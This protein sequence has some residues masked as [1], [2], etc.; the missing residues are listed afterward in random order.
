MKSRPSF[1]SRIL[2]RN[3][4][5]QTRG[6]ITGLQL[7]GKAEVLRDRWGIPHIYAESM[8]DLLAAQGFVHAQDRLWQMESMRRLSEGR[9][10]EVAGDGTLF[11]DCFSRL[12]D[13]SFMKRQM[14]QAAT[15]G[16]RGLLQAYADGVNAYLAMRGKDLPLEFKSM[17]FVPEKWSAIDGLSTVPFLTWFL[18]GA[19]YSERL[20]ALARGCSLTS[21]D[22]NDMFPCYPGAVLPDDPYF[23]TLAHL[24]IGALHPAATAFHTGLSGK[25]SASSLRE[26]LLAG[27][28]VAAGS[29]MEIGAGPGGGSNNWTVAKGKDGLPLLANDP[30]LG[31]ALPAVWYF[32]H[33]CVPGE[34][35][36]AGTSLAGVPGIVIGRNEHVAWSMTNAMLD[37]VDVLMLRVDPKN[38]TRYMRGGSEREMRREDV[39]IGLPKGKSV[40]LPLYRTELGPAITAVTEGVEAVAALRW[41][42]TLPEGKIKDRSFGGIFSLLRARSAAEALEAARTM[43]YVSQNLVVADDKGHIAWHATGA[44][45]VRSG[46]SGRLPADG[47][48][49]ADWIGFVPYDSLPSLMDPPEGWIATAN[50]RPPGPEKGTPLSYTWCSPYRYQHIVHELSAMRS[51]RVRRL[52]RA[53]DECPF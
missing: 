10:S 4:W 36:V 46:Y 30:H 37:P 24:K 52:P 15:E 19:A 7:S 20:L 53:S 43:Y 25:Y 49:D 12:I 31:V 39:V 14:L 13:M 2:L 41:F 51:A 22:W 34:V 42:G 11:Y 32:C 3:A 45:P 48:A 26:A 33:L 50:N 27:A 17:G 40:T 6:Q 47:S 8:H 44:A 9:L 5:P 35:N 28:G 38:P 16:E 21:R 1:L 23:G 29:V 18:L